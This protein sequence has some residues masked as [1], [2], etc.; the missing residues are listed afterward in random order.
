M[1]APDKPTPLFA[2]D[3]QTWLP[4]EF[5]ASGA[6]LPLKFVDNFTIQLAIRM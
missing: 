2:H 1:S 3:F 4:L 6:I 5:G